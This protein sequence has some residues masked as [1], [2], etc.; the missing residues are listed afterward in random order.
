MTLLLNQFCR[1]KKAEYY[2]FPGHNPD[3]KHCY[4]SITRRFKEIWFKTGFYIDNGKN[5][6]VHS[7]RHYYVIKR[8]NLWTEQGIPLNNM[9][10]CLANQLGH[11]SPNETFYYFHLIEEG[12]KI[13]SK[14]D[15]TGKTIMEAINE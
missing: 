1:D 13:I 7:L 14:K 9:L 12:L 5:P 6:T 3:K 2:I 10:I 8:I 15:K 11:S 4:S